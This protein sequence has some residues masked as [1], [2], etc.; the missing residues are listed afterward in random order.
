MSESS[1]SDKDRFTCALSTVMEYIRHVAEKTK[2]RILLD[3]GSQIS[4]IREGIIPQ[5]DTCHMQ[6]FNLTTVGGDTVNHQLRVVKCT[7]G[8][9]DDSIEQKSPTY[10][11]E[12]TM[13]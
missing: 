5:S 4:L 8:S 2:V 11:D 13:W 7:L 12:D 3:T 6:Y 10:R 1:S 9:L